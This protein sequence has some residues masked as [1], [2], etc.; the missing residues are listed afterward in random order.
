MAFSEVSEE[1][2]TL[3]SQKLPSS[4]TPLSFEAPPR[5]TPASIRI[6]LIFP[7]TR[8]ICLHF[9]CCMC[10]SIFIQICAVGSKTRIFSASDCVLAVQGSWRS[11]KPSKVDDFGTNRKR[12]YDFLLVRHCDYGPILHSFRDMVTYW[13]KWPIFATPLPTPYFWSVRGGH[14]VRPCLD[15]LLH[16]W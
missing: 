9:C 15:S 16:Q 8:I 5:G 7:E 13:L 10:G 11:S 4:T 14:T 12:V 6:C 2:V 3:K 1:V